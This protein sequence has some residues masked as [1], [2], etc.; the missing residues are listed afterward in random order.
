MF[1]VTEYA[2]LSSEKD[3]F[4]GPLHQL[5]KLCC[6][7]IGYIKLILFQG[8]DKACFTS[9]LRQ[10]YGVVHN[11]AFLKTPLQSRRVTTTKTKFS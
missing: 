11:T 5:G 10:S 7:V 1:I 2:A 4:Y 8:F 6:P 3:L 9:A